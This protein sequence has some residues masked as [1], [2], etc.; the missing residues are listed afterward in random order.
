VTATDNPRHV[1]GGT[2]TAPHQRE[3]APGDPVCSRNTGADAQGLPPRVDDG[4]HHSPQACQQ[5]W[6]DSGSS[7]AGSSNTD[8]RVGPRTRSQSAR[9]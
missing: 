2:A 5:G 1:D 4:Q 9:D 6:R 3:G 8:H 7:A